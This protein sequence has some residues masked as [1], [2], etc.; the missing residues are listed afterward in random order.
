MK[1]LKRRPRASS[2]PCWPAPFGQPHGAANLLPFHG[3][4]RRGV[5]L[6]GGY[7]M[8]A[9]PAMV[10]RY[11]NATAEHEDAGRLTMMR[12]IAVNQGI[13]GGYGIDAAR[14]FDVQT[15]KIERLKGVESWPAVCWPDAESLA[16]A[17]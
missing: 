2:A 16:G 3:A 1:E 14:W 12:Q 5:G 6:R 4:P 9:S 8:Q 13:N 11:R 15:A 10:E 7:C 17:Q